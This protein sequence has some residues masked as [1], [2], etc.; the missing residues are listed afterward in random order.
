MDANVYTVGP[1]KFGNLLRQRR[2]WYVGFITNVLRYKDLFGVKQGNLGLLVLPSSFISIGLAIILFGYA[3]VN[4]LLKSIND[5][6]NYSSVGYD[7]LPFIE[8]PNV[9]VFYFNMNPV[10]ILAFMSLLMGFSM[11][12]ISKRY[13]RENSGMSILYFLYIAVYWLLFAFWWMV[14]IGYKIFKKRV[15]W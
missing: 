10:R 13:S 3:V 1:N 4:F 14:A 8:L 9:D 5:L 7:F 12:L 11:L 2:R 6:V 15:A